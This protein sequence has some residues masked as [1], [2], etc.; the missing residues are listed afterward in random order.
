LQKTRLLLQNEKNKKTSFRYFEFFPGFFFNYATS[1]KSF[2]NYCKYFA[3]TYYHACG[4]C[5]MSSS[6]S[7][8]IPQTSTS[9]SQTSTSKI[10]I[11]TSTIAITNDSNNNKSY[12]NGNIK[13]KKIYE[14]EEGVVDENLKVHGV[15]NLRLADASIIPRIPTSPIAS[16]CMAIGDIAADLV[17]KKM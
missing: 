13:N 9:T 1:K 3:G 5:S 2:E 4:T 7:T 11:P 8:S 17:L 6:T 10:K 14:I 12:N 15:Q 16:I